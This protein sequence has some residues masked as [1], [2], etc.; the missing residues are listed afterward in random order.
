MKTLYM[1]QDQS[2][3]RHFPGENFALTAKSQVSR[4]E[5][6][7]EDERKEK[8]KGKSSQKL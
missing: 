7:R 3:Q 1:T 5:T 8:S 2:N 6:R 4:L